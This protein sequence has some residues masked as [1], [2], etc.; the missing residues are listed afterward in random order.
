MKKASFLNTLATISYCFCAIIFIIWASII[1]AFCLGYYTPKI[2]YAEDIIIES[3]D[4]PRIEYVNN[5]PV[6]RLN[7]I[8]ESENPNILADATLIVKGKTTPKTDD[9]GNVIDENIVTETK[10][11]LTSTNEDVI[12]VPKEAKLNEPIPITV[13]KNADGTNKGG[14]CFINIKNEQGLYM[15][16]PLCVFVDIPVTELEM[17]STNM[18]SE[19][20]EGEKVYYIYES[21]TANITTS[22]LPANS[23]DPTHLDNNSVFSKFR[24]SAKTYEYYFDSASAN[25]VVSI[26]GNGKI[27]AQKVGKTKIWVRALKTYDDI[28]FVNNYIP[29]QPEDEGYI[30]EEKLVGRYVYACMT[31][32]VKEVTLT[33]IEIGSGVIK[34]DLFKTKSFSASDLGIT[35]KAS[36]G[37]STYFD[38][39]LDD[40]I[41]TSQKESELKVEKDTKNNKWNFTVLQYPSN[42]LTINV[43]LPN[44]EL[45]ATTSS[46][47]VNLDNVKAL[48]FEGTSKSDSNKTY[49][50]QVLKDIVKYGETITTAYS[51]TLWEW[52]N[53]IEIVPENGKTST[54]YFEV[55]L[56]AVGVYHNGTQYKDKV[57][58][59]EQGEEIIGLS[60]VT[61][62]NFGR[63]VR[64]NS[65][66]D[67]SIV[68][69]LARGTIV[70]RACVIK[71]DIDGN[72]IDTDGNIMRFDQYGNVLDENGAIKTENIP[73]F[74]SIAQ[75]KDVLFKVVEDLVEV[76]GYVEISSG[77]GNSSVNTEIGTMP[78][79]VSCGSSVEI[80]LEANS[81]GALFDA[82]NNTST[83]GAWLRAITSK[84]DEATLVPTL[85]YEEIAQNQQ[86]YYL[87][88]EFNSSNLPNEYIEQNVQLM[89][90]TGT[91]S[92]SDGYE[93]LGLFK[94]YVI[95]V[96]IEKIQINTSLDD[97]TTNNDGT[98]VYTY[99]KEVDGK[100]VYNLTGIVTY[101]SET[102]TDTNKNELSKISVKWGMYDKDKNFKE[103]ELYKPTLT[104]G[105]V[106]ILENKTKGTDYLE[107]TPLKISNIS[108]EQAVTS[109][110]S[111]YGAIEAY[112]PTTPT[113]QNEESNATDEKKTNEKIANI[114][115][116]EL[117]KEFD[118]VCS[119]LNN[120]STTVFDTIHIS[121]T[122][123]S[124]FASK[125]LWNTNTGYT[126][127]D[128]KYMMT[129]S[130]D[131]LHNNADDTGG[132]KLREQELFGLKITGGN[133]I[134][135]SSTSKFISFEIPSEYSALVSITK[136]YRLIYR[137]VAFDED[138]I[139]EINVV[140]TTDDGLNIR[141]KYK[142]KFEFKV[143]KTTTE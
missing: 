50:D 122:L 25:D 56:F 131:V 109:E 124:D 111:Q 12:T 40:I 49:N 72:P 48:N 26:D 61:F 119:S 134:N 30:P 17:T 89:Y 99:A 67:P 100:L 123:Y 42:G 66:T 114:R 27:T 85:T 104:A 1:V 73:T 121:G 79:A 13:T 36:N 78:I 75:S 39:L 41:I 69:T 22:F 21:E 81:D 135:I 118:I 93:N 116:K 136:D 92:T 90:Y 127:D 142:I 80:T 51:D 107:P 6:L 96:P 106:K 83:T 117:G 46:F 120:S 97:Y 76:S 63:E 2:V 88:V 143:E 70:L 57:F 126:T 68:Q 65:L 8:S 29:D 45:S 138:K 130:S 133:D 128:E 91:T 140:M 53:N 44:S 59:N 103:F 141:Q 71:T 34:L 3:A 19:D 33:A 60:D 58:T 108:F 55:K 129:V 125:L 84:K 5:Q 113:T 86:K 23:K 15:K 32:E 64:G 139:I 102:N 95:D 18:Q 31:I 112:T 74:F 82:Y 132:L 24:K 7:G 98:K 28:D 4:N 137:S 52:E 9:D 11:Y 105:T 37:S 16:S 101:E 38:A 47:D 94:F 20:V 62:A 54:S 14:F 115:I 43:T 77:D 10:I 110:T 35:L 87:N